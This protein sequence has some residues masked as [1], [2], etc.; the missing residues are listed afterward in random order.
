VRTSGR[1]V[2]AA[3]AANLIGGTSYVLTKVALAGLTETSLVV[4]RTIVALAVFLPLASAR[5]AAVLRARGVDRRLLVTMGAAGYALPLAL[6][7]YGMRYSTA[8]NA[9][10]LIGVEPLGIALLGALVLN[11]RLG[12]GRILALALGTIGATVLVVDGIPFVTAAWAPHPFGD[13]LLV[14]AALAW[15]PYTIA[16]KQLLARYDATALSAASL[17]VALPF[18]IP[19]AA[20]EAAATPWPSGRLVPAL[21]AA[22]VLGLVVSAGMTVLWNVALRGM[23]ASRLAGFVFL[24]PLAGVLLASVALGEPIGRFALAGGVLVLAAVYLLLVEER[25]DAARAGASGTVAA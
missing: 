25:A 3:I 23:D 14:A 16:G 19:V 9:S 15:A 11:E 24:Q 8:T 10:L 4:V 22:V 1:A 17:V 21:A 6:A 2:A 18:L 5:I 20:I 13:L 7:S 12:R